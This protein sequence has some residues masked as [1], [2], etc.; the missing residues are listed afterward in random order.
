MNNELINNNALSNLI[1]ETIM[2]DI[3]LGK[4]LPG[5]K[6]VEAQYAE[7]FGTSRAPVREAFYL[8]TLE[9]MVKRIPRKGTVVRGFSS[10]ET[11]DIIEIRCFLENMALEKLRNKKYDSYLQNMEEI[12]KKT[13]SIKNQS[14]EYTELNYQFHEQLILASESEV[15]KTNYARLGNILLTIQNVAFMKE[16]DVNNSISEHEQLVKYIYENNIDEAKKLLD[17]HNRSVLARVERNLQ[18]YKESTK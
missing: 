9:G 4:L 12:I 10:E 11:K 18:G 6:L 3:L 1:K 17:D 15:I 7:A 5:D 2:R 14:N 16:E 13:K 8:L